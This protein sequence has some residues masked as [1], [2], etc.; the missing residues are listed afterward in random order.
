MRMPLLLP[1]AL[2]LTLSACATNVSTRSSVR[3]TP[4]E[5]TA[6]CAEPPPLSLPRE[7][8]ELET[9]RWGWMC[10]RL[11][12]DCASALLS[13]EQPNTQK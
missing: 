5:C 2:C 8:L 12:D 13:A 7:A 6:R 1:I 3:P 10:K 4:W 11:H 9:R